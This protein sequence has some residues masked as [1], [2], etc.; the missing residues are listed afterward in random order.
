MP[1]LRLHHK[2]IPLW[3]SPIAQDFGVEAEVADF[4]CKHADLKTENGHQ[5][6][7]RPRGDDRRSCG[8]SGRA[9][10]IT[11]RSSSSVNPSGGIAYP[12]LC[13]SLALRLGLGD[14]LQRIRFEPRQTKRQHFAE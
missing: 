11:M 7:V 10:S 13:R 4:L 8:A 14:C 6:V 3:A 1:C 9:R 2:L 5:R 12:S